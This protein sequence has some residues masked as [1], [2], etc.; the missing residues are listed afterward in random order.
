MLL[1][2][3]TM[4]EIFATCRASRVFIG[5]QQYW[6]VWGM[7][8]D[9]FRL[10]RSCAKPA[11]KGD[12]VT[13]DSLGTS[14][15]ASIMAES[16]S[17][18]GDLQRTPWE[19]VLF[20]LPQRPPPPNHTVKSEEWSRKPAREVVS[21]FSGGSVLRMWLL[22]PFQRTVDR[23]YTHSAAVST[24]VTWQWPE[25]L[26]IRTW[27]WVIF[28]LLTCMW[29]WT[30][31]RCVPWDCVFFLE[32]VTK[33]ISTALSICFYPPKTSDSVDKISQTVFS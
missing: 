12:W 11:V 16:H 24:T 32:T 2:V 29:P 15:T 33:Y 26:L 5:S 6:W 14:H 17:Y 21:P 1:Q 7:P 28:Q 10:A 13:W 22:H 3:C 25:L 19:P 4:I 20:T 27:F 31:H 18:K 30:N 8:P 9:S 23:Y